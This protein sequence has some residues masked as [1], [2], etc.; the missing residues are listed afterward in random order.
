[1]DA[2]LIDHER[3]ATFWIVGLYK[4][5]VIDKEA[6]DIVA[7]GWRALYA[8]VIKAHAEDKNIDYSYA[9]LQFHQY[10]YSKEQ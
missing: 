1:M 2:L 5:K 8:V 9:L 3:N 4:G 6:A 7:W 10:A